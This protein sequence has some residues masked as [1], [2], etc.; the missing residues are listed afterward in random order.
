MHGI[1]ERLLEL[2]G[3]DGASLSTVDGR[4][5]A[6]QGR[7]RAPTRRCRATCPL[8]DTLGNECLR[9]GEITVLRAT[10]RARDCALR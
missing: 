3:A 7:V 5:R 6:L 9:S 8:E 1:V 4:D 2:R 10:D